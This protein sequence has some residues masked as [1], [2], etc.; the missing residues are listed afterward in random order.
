MR[1]LLGL[2]LSAC[3]VLACSVQHSARTAAPA[4]VDPRQVLDA[5]GVPQALADEG[6]ELVRE[7]LGPFASSSHLVA[8]SNITFVPDDCRYFLAHPEHHPQFVLMYLFDVGVPVDVPP[9]R[10]VLQGL[11]YFDEAGNLACSTVPDC[12]HRTGL[13]PPFLLNSTTAVLQRANMLHPNGYNAAQL[14]QDLGPLTTVRGIN[15][16]TDRSRLLWVVEV[17]NTYDPRHAQT[18]TALTIYLDPT[19]GD[20]VSGS[21]PI[22]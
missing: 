19:T 6:S 7:R 21:P 18:E 11:V 10:R 15:R 16:T 9:S 4:T 1:L 2:V 5:A 8:A 22:S 13:C 20:E 14:T 3:L 12:A 17:V